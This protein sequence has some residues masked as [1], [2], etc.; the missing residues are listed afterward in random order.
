VA[1]ASDSRVVNGNN[2][3]WKRSV[4]RSFLDGFPLSLSVHN[5]EAGTAIS[6]RARLGSMASVFFAVSGGLGVLV[7]MKL[8]V[9]SILLIGIGT[10]S[11]PMI[12]L[13]L[14]AGGVFGL[15]GFWALARLAF[16]AFV[17]RSQEKLLTMV[18][19]IKAAVKGMKH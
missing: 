16:R 9:F 1:N 7:G 17:K 11:L 10:F 2:L 12:I 5:A 14:A 4:L 3:T 8:A 13:I 19:K 18:E 6:A 15:G